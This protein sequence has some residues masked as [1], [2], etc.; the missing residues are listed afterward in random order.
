MGWLRLVGSLKS[1]VSS[2]KYRLFH[3]ALL[4]KRPIILRSLLI[5]AIPYRFSYA[6]VIFLYLVL[7]FLISP[8]LSCSFYLPLSPLYIH[9]YIHIYTHTHAHKNIYTHRARRRWY[10]LTCSPFIS[11]YFSL[12]L[13]LADSLARLLLYIHPHMHMYTCIYP[14]LTFSY[15]YIQTSV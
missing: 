3:R 13:S 1:Y 14:R 8:S 6:P 12:Y 10:H 11:L 9:T 5:V 4:Q 7:F 15:I 2:T